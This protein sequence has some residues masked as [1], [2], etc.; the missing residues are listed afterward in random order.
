VDVVERVAALYPNCCSEKKKRK[1]RKRKRKRKRRRK[2][3]RKRKRMKKKMKKK[4]K[5]TKKRKK[6][7]LCKI[8]KW[9]TEDFWKLREIRRGWAGFPAPHT[10]P[11]VDYCWL[12]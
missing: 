5:K 9:T 1:K 12:T 3:R 11:D 8:A 2:R 7:V 6:L 4:K 10:P